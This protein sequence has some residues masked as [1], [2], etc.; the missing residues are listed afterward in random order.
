[1]FNESHYNYHNNYNDSERLDFMSALI[2]YALNLYVRK[3]GFAFK[4]LAD[5][6]DISLCANKELLLDNLDSCKLNIAVECTSTIEVVSSQW[7]ELYAGNLSVLN[8]VPYSI[9]IS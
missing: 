6:M 7:G 5:F 2:Q 8:G 4:Q 3:G 1:M 9:I